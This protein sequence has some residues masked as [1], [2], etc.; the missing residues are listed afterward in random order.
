M[1]H[2]LMVDLD[3]PILTRLRALCLALPGAA[4][5]IS[6]GHPAFYTDKVFAYFGASIKVDGAYQQ[7][8][9]SLVVKPHPDEAQALLEEPRCYR[10]A[11]LGPSGWVGVDLDDETDWEEVAELVEE[12]Y[13]ATARRRLVAE[14]EARTA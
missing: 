9:T 2:P 4:E 7:H 6:H 5:K 8:P 3:S 10:P 11:Y 14:L 13:R 1:A 12:S